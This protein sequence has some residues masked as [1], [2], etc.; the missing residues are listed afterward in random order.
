MTDRQEGAKLSK[1]RM[2]LEADM[3][4]EIMLAYERD[5]CTDDLPQAVADELRIGL[6]HTT[7]W[8]CFGVLALDFIRTLEWRVPSLPDD[9]MVMCQRFR[10][11]VPTLRGFAIYETDSPAGG[12]PLFAWQARDWVEAWKPPV[13]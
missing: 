10:D 8:P 4:Y 2:P 11:A 5:D 7:N 6:P 3:P 9:P 1:K 12:F 13:F